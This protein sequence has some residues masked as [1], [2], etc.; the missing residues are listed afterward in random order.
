M[1]LNHSWAVVVDDGH[2]SVLSSRIAAEDIVPV[3]ALNRHSINREEASA[4]LEEA[5]ENNR[6]AALMLVG[7][8][9]NLYNFRKTLKEP[10]R[11]RVV[12]EVIR[13]NHKPEYI[14]E[15]I[16]EMCA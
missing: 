3:R 13:P 4:Y 6:Y 5:L 2:V 16:E 15:R 14:D 12:A 8:P 11:R 10:V 7:A 9:D 1:T